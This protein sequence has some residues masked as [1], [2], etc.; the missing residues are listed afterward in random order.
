MQP[1]LAR[2]RSTSRQCDEKA[3]TGVLVL[4][5]SST[6][7]TTLTSYSSRSTSRLM[8]LVPPR[9]TDTVVMIIVVTVI[10]A[11]RPPFLF[12]AVRACRPAARCHLVIC[13][14]VRVRESGFLFFLFLLPSTSYASHCPQTATAMVGSL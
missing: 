12:S 1:Q 13:L 6:P 10:V 11:S 2:A 7:S 3:S 14:A 9:T 4:L 5:R 8:M